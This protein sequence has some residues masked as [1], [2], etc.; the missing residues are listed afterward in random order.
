VYVF[1]N[2]QPQLH[3][4]ETVV[5]IIMILLA[6]EMVIGWGLREFCFARSLGPIEQQVRLAVCAILLYALFGS[7]T[8]WQW[9]LLPSRSAIMALVRFI[10]SSIGV[11][12]AEIAV[13]YVVYSCAK[14]CC[15]CLTL[16]DG[17]RSLEDIAA[18]QEEQARQERAA[19]HQADIEAR[20]AKMHKK[21]EVKQTRYRE[22][23]EV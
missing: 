11:V 7:L 5:Y 10:F 14:G 12:F 1:I 2:T 15:P 16:D 21:L 6:I 23:D 20:R 4:V 3:V 9:T 17:T 22:E 8:A 19:K 18:E 13:W